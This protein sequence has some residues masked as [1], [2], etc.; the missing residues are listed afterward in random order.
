MR[1]LLLNAIAGLRGGSQRSIRTLGS[2][3]AGA[4]HDVHVACPAG[5]WADALSDEGRVHVH[6]LPTTCWLSGQLHQAGMRNALRLTR[7]SRRLDA[8][9]LH[10]FQ[11]GSYLLA[12]AVGDALGIA[13]A[14][15]VL[16]PLSP[17]HRFGPG[18]VVAVSEAFADDALRAGATDIAVIPN[19]I[20]LSAFPPAPEPP[21]RVVT[22]VSRLDGHLIR[23]AEAF[24]ASLT[25]ITATD[26]IFQ[27]AGDGAALDHLRAAGGQARMLGHV[28]DIR[29]VYRAST[30]MVGAGRALL[31]AMASGTPCINLAPTGCGGVVTPASVDRMA[32]H[33][34]SGRHARPASPED[35]AKAIEGL[36][37]DNDLRAR[38]RA[39]GPGWV[40]GRYDVAQGVPR[41]EAVWDVSRRQARYRSQ[42]TRLAATTALVLRL[43]ATKG[44]RTLNRRLRR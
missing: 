23:S 30:L 5:A 44:W 8:Q 39:W 38:L 13:T 26:V 4:G 20:D 16:G 18:P 22:L 19:R 29:R 24:L 35:L 12:R 27:V 10:T 15:T 37:E 43:G 3:L 21:G 28:Q 40:R 7:L 25:H 9:V 2:A 31:E 36:L 17:G 42:G 34:M 6:R 1:V 32:R 14:H 11:Y 33:N 41:I